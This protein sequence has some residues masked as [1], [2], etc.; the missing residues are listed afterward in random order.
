MGTRPPVRDKVE[1]ATR[2]L[3]SRRKPL[4]RPPSSSRCLIGA[5]LLAYRRTTHIRMNRPGGCASLPSIGLQRSTG[6]HK[7]SV[8]E[9][10]TNRGNAAPSTS[11]GYTPAHPRPGNAGNMPTQGSLSPKTSIGVRPTC[12]QTAPSPERHGG[13]KQVVRNVTPPNRRKSPPRA[14]FARQSKA[15]CLWYRWYA[16]VASPTAAH[17]LQEL[18]ARTYR[19]R[20]RSSSR[21]PCPA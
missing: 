6:A 11:V 7:I 12:P 19:H 16:T 1:N 20:G 3:H 21:R 10:P 18:R 5:R 15:P 13:W 17:R 2:S 4:V 9:L 8:G 14:A